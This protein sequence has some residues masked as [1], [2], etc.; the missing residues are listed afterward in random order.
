M[1]DPD[2]QHWMLHSISVVYAI[3]LDESESF[4]VFLIGMKCIHITLINVI[5]ESV[6]RK[7]MRLELIYGSVTMK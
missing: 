4:Y 6:T 5:F 3:V 2:P 7:Y 1:L